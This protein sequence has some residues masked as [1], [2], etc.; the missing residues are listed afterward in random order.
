MRVVLLPQAQH[1]LDAVTDPLLS[2]ISRRIDAL[3]DFPEMGAPMVGPYRGYR[4]L[5]VDFF[6]VVYKVRPGSIE[7]QFVRD[8]RRRPPA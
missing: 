8:C 6:R 2:R 1:G 4:S 3:R 7:I 5:V